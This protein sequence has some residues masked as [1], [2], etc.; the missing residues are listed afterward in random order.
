M[1]S[2]AEAA[3][4]KRITAH[5]IAAD[6]TEI[7]LVPHSKDRNG[8][9]GY[10]VTAGKPRAS[11]TGRM[12]PQTSGRATERLS[13]DGSSKDVQFMLMLPASAQIGLWDRLRH[14]GVDYEVV[15]IQAN[16]DFQTKADVVRA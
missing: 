14:A 2:S 5:F 9:G 3:A 4:Q 16:R 10:V 15:Y 12:I 1:I 13:L 11:Q 8:A 7:V 6:P